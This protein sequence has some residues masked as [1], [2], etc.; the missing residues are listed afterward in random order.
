MKFYLI[1]E[2]SIVTAKDAAMIAQA[3]HQQMRDV[4]LAHDL[5]LDV[6]V[7]WA[8]QEADVPSDGL[9]VVILDDPDQAGALG[10]HFLTPSGK[11]YARVFV[12]PTL[13][14]GGKVLDGPE[15][16]C[17]VVSHEVIEARLDLFCNYWADGPQIRQGS[18]YALEG[19]D[20]VQGDT[21]PQTVATEHGSATC[22]V[23]NFLLPAWFN[24]DSPPG[25]R[26][27]FMGTCPGPFKLAKGGY[28]IVRHS[29]GSEAQVFGEFLSSPEGVAKFARQAQA[30]THA[31]SRTARRL[32]AAHQPPAAPQE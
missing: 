24:A 6:V 26:V 28:M 23:S 32:A 20:A 10:Y 30:K 25:S 4:G 16:V 29:A 8:G 14:E 5:A 27:D 21:Y 12:K 17:S 19:C 18:Q 2:S 11:P 13:E 9:P 22:T 15:S 3:C 31:A 1:N 7:Y